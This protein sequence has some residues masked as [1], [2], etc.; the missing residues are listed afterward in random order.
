MKFHTRFAYSEL[1]DL[2]HA[3]DVKVPWELSRL[4]RLPILALAYRRF[5]EERYLEALLA[6]LEGWDAANPVGYGVN[7]VVGMEASLRAV[8]VI[9]AAEILAGTAGAE[10]FARS[11]LL[12]FL[13][14]HGRFVY[15]NLEHSDVNGNHYTACLVGLLYLGLYLPELTES[16]RW[17]SFARRELA[18]EMPLQVY[19]DGVC[20]EGSIPYHRLV[21]ELFLHAAVLARRLDLELGAAYWER[22]EKMFDFVHAYTKP[23]GEAP[24]WGDTDDGRVLTLGSQRLQDHRY[25]LAVGAALFDRADLLAASGPA[26]LDAFALLERS[27]TARL[28]EAWETARS[29]PGQSLPGSAGFPA[30]G[31]Y[32][33]RREG[34]FCLVDCGDVGLRGRGG[35]GHNDALAVEIALGGV[36]VLTDCGA[37]SYTRSVTDRVR[38]LSVSS[39]NVAEVDGTEPATISLARLPHT[40][41]CPVELVTWDPSGDL[42]VGRHRG[43][44]PVTGGAYERRIEHLEAGGFR[45]TDRLEGEGRHRVE[46]RFHFAEAWQETAI[47]AGRLVVHRSCGQRVELRWD[48]PEEARAELVEGVRYPSYDAPRARRVLSLMLDTALPIAATF[49]L[50]AL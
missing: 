40:T 26:S 41:A 4:Q 7:W 42:F 13:V 35:H 36:D 33:L 6:E 50:R 25:L 24:V 28:A 49:V 3:S 5:G 43:F 29:S 31:F 37:S 20:H 23:N 27:Q 30:G 22:L 15:R 34:D 46:W 16:R 47:E 8:N 39:H 9:W 48:L 1:L 11:R 2:S 32:L 21:L 14:E 12:P 45:L 38:T 17:V 10:R 44:E 19:P 18:R